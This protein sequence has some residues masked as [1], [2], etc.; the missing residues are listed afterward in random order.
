MYRVGL[1]PFSILGY[2]VLAHSLSRLIETK[3]TRSLKSVCESS[4]II[5]TYLIS[6]ACFEL[7]LHLDQSYSPQ[8]VFTIISCD[9]FI[10][11]VV[12]SE[13]SRE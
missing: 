13:L 11:Y 7:T 12:K 8:K 3:Q 6:Q 1:I 2:C 9:E 10:N 4:A 5:R